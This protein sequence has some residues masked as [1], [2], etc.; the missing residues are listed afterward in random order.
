M[1]IKLGILLVG[2]TY[3]G[4]L[5]YAVKRSIQYIDFD[6]K[7]H[8]LSFLSNKNLYGEKYVRAYKLSLIHI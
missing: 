2:F 3:A 6:L 1:L 4:V 5:P 7:K 8:T